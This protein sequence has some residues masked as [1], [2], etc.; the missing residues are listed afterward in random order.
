MG[1][2]YLAHEAALDRPVALK[3]IAS[4]DPDDDARERFAR[5]ARAIARLQHPNIVAI[6]RVGE[7]EGRP[8]IAYEYVDGESLDTV[9]TPIPWTR[10]LERLRSCSRNRWPGRR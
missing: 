10:A 2:V 6:F 9:P 4:D 8:Y 5:E 1:C 7:V 3:V